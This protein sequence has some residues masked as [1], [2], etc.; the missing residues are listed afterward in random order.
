MKTSC[1]SYP[2]RLF[3]IFLLML[4]VLFLVAP[5]FPAEWFVVR[6]KAG[7][8]F[9]FDRG[10]GTWMP[11]NLLWGTM[12]WFRIHWSIRALLPALVA[13]LCF[14]PQ[15]TTVAAGCAEI[16]TI[17]RRRFWCT[18]ALGLICGG[19]FAFCHVNPE[20]NRHFGDGSSLLIEIRAA[21]YVFPSEV[22][23]MHLFNAVQNLSVTIF[24]GMDVP[25]FTPLVTT[26]SSGAVFMWASAIVALL[27][28][29]DR[30]ERF[31]LFT[32]PTL[33]GALT[34]FFGYV[35]TTFLVM[36][37]MA[38]LFAS[39]AWM[40]QGETHI[41]R[42]NRMMLVFASV[43]I[44]MLAHG[45]GVVLLPATGLLILLIDPRRKGFRRLFVMKDVWIAIGFVAIVCVPYYL[46]FIRPFVI[47]RNGYLGNLHGGADQFN[48]VQWN[49]ESAH[50]VSNYVY[51]SMI[52]WGHFI[53]I[54][55]GFLVGAPLAIPMTF[56]AI[57]LYDSSIRSS[58][59]L[60]PLGPFGP[61]T[62]EREILTVIIL[63]TVS[64]ISVPLLWEMDFGGWGDWNIITSYLY[65]LQFM[66]WFLLIMAGRR[67]NIPV[68]SVLVPALIVQIAMWIGL[69]LQFY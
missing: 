39:A 57:S 44:A 16:L 18:V 10:H 15:T 34:Q 63:A 6:D 45:A 12:G 4:A 36:T 13:L 42:R 32:G 41:S 29:R 24:G 49:F 33:A 69:I 64:S 58:R 55:M 56:T 3:K 50:A 30:V 14:W 46:M 67:I 68:R 62:Y 37:A 54:G 53:D 20:I 5:W 59:S 19:L 35:E 11:M 7:A 27:L 26:C 22:L 61:F 66:G 52:S 2:L 8:L 65:P 43:S 1:N 40:L 23:T 47:D 31:F 9:K 25:L 28:G 21:G 60:R 17:T 48:F 51:Y 38:M